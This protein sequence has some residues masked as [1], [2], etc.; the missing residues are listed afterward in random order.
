VP[1]QRRHGVATLNQA[2][3]H[4]D[5]GDLGAAQGLLSEM[6]ATLPSDPRKARPV[7]AEAVVLQT[8]VLLSLGDP[9]AARGWAAYGHATFRRLYGDRDRRTLHTLGLLAAVLTRV[10]AHGRAASRYQTLIEIFTELE[11]PR[12]EKSLAARAD[13]ATVEHARGHCAKAR[14]DLADVIREHQATFGAVHP[15]GVRMLARLAA[16]YRDCGD[17][18]RAVALLDQAR[19]NAVGLSGDIIDL[20]VVASRAQADPQH[21][22]EVP[23]PVDEEIP[24]LPA[25]VAEGPFGPP[26]STVS[27]LPEHPR[28]VAWA[29][30]P[31]PSPHGKAPAPKMSPAAMVLIAAIIGIVAVILLFVML[32]STLRSG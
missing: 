2:R 10:G 22:C 15:L 1:L 32:I 13:L 26:F 16:M 7:E 27:Y 19:S 28:L 11:G 6:L 9:H 17:P 4:V 29:P 25:P 21:V 23:A 12:S 8:G 14:S 18:D 24:A 31:P 3:A 5:A 20:L 30:P